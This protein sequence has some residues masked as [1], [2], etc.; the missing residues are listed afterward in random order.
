GGCA[1]C[2]LALR[3][4]AAAGR[5]LARAAG[6]IAALYPGG[7]AGWRRAALREPWAWLVPDAVRLCRSAAGGIAGSARCAGQA[8]GLGVRRRAAAGGRGAAAWRRRVAPASTDA[9]VAAAARS[10]SACRGFAASG[11]GCLDP[12]LAACPLGCP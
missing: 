3:R 1:L 4:R 2:A 10:R 5:P 9:A 6:G 7:C 11:P 12:R 8:T